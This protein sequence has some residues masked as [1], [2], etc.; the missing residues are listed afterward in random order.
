MKYQEDMVWFTKCPRNFL[1][2]L[3]MP[4]LGPHPSSS[5]RPHG[6]RDRVVVVFSSGISG[7]S[8]HSVNL[9]LG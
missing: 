7:H 8:I 1:D 6:E 2:C 4:P 3:G 5:L 9:D